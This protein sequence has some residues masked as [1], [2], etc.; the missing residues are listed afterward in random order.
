[1]KRINAVKTVVLFLV[2]FCIYITIETLFR[3][4]S[5]ALM[6]ICGG[7]AIIILDKI[8]NKVSWD[9]DIIIQCSIGSLIVT[10]MELIIGSLFLAGYLPVMWD[11]S[12]MPMNYRGIICL[13]FSIAWMFLSFAGI[14]VADSIN[15]YIFEELPIPYYK[16]FGKTFLTFKKKQCKL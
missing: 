10:L 14:L 16:I 11:Y 12:S 4:Y 15:Y 9:L 5:Y 2:G 13:P 8:N 1:M 3:G 7:L 6:G